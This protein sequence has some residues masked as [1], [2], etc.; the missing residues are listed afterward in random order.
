MLWEVD[1]GR[2]VSGPDIRWYSGLSNPFLGFLLFAR[3]AATLNAS[4]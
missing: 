2:V 4:A 1:N 3:K